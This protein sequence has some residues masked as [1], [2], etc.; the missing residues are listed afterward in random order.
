MAEWSEASDDDLAGLPPFIRAMIEHAQQ[1]QTPEARAAQRRRFN[2]Q[3]NQGDMLFETFPTFN[4]ARTCAKCGYGEKE[5]RSLFIPEGRAPQ[6]TGRHDAIARR[7]RRCDYSWMERPIDSEDGPPRTGTLT[8]H[9]FAWAISSV[10]MDVYGKD[11][12]GDPVMAPSEL[13]ARLVK[14]A[15]DMGHR[16]PD[17]LPHP[18]P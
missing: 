5:A 15:K 7:C 17:D 12:P 18:S 13:M 8:L 3:L 4:L 2:E 11:E 9:E 16:V 10:Y 1:Q 6:L 14:R